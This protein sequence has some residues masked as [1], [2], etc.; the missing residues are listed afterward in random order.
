[1]MT[2]VFDDVSRPLHGTKDEQK[3]RMDRVQAYCVKLPKNV[4][5]AYM[6]LAV[7]A[8]YDEQQLTLIEKWCAHNSININDWQIPVLETLYTTLEQKRVYQTFFVN[9]AKTMEEQQNQSLNGFKGV[10]ISEQKK[11]LNDFNQAS[12]ETASSLLFQI[13]A[14]EE[15]IRAFN[16]DSDLTARFSQAVLEGVDSGIQAQ[17]DIFNAGMAQALGDHMSRIEFGNDVLEQKMNLISAE[18]QK[19]EKLDVPNLVAPL[20]R[21]LTLQMGSVADHAKAVVEKL[22][23]GMEAQTKEASEKLTQRNKDTKAAFDRSASAAEEKFGELTTAAE[24]K[25]EGVIGKMGKAIESELWLERVKI[26]SGVAII[27]ILTG[28]VMSY[29]LF[30]RHWKF[31]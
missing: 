24:E 19:I 9:V 5:G 23:V 22:R 12:A 2:T 29:W 4:Q 27:G 17:A 15:M 20:T 26:W 6:E 11:V 1:M 8:G 3:A 28:P 31:A 21:Q 16:P 18:I 10:I 30:F 14:V 13:G 7:A 25:F